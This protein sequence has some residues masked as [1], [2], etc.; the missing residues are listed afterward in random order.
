MARLSARLHLLGLIAAAVVPVWLFAAYLLAQ[1]AFTERARFESAAL[2]VARQ[3]SLVVEGEL[4]NLVTVLEGLSKSAA[5]AGGDL[6]TLHGEAVRLVQGTDRIILLRDLNGR[7]FVNT[8]LPYGTELPPA[9]PLSATEVA[10]LK[11]SQPVVSDVYASPVSNEYRIAVALPVRGPHGESWLLAITVP[12]AHIRDVMMPAVPVGW[13]LGV[14]DRN[15]NYVARSQLHEK[16]TGKPGL[17]EYLE[18]VVGRAGTFTSRNFQGMTLLAGYYR[19]EFSDWFYTANVPLSAVQAP[20]WRSLGAIGAIALVAMLVSGALAYVVGKGIARAAGDLAIRA[21]ALGHA[22][23]VAAMSTTVSEFAA[24]ADALAAAERA[25]AERASELETVLETAPAAVWFTYDP[26]A[27]QVIRN[28]FAAELMGLPTDIRKSFGAPDLVIDT[29]AL[30]DGHAVSREDRPLSRAMRGEQT[31]NEEFAYILPSGVER[32]LLSS[33]R[34]IR[35]AA[36]KIIG[37]VQISLDI[38]E[39]KRGEEQ[40]KLLVNE[41][42]HRVKN[43]LAVVQAIASQTLRNATSLPEAGRSL[44]SRLGSLAKAHD[45]LT[46][47]NWSGA[48]LQDLI[49]TSLAPHAGLDRFQLSGDSVWLPPNL[50][51]SLALAIHELTTN[52]IKYGALSTGGGTVS[53][54]WTVSKQAEQRRL[55]I[56]WREQGGPPVAPAERKGFGTRMLER[57]LD[58]ESGGSVTTTFEPTGVVCVFGVN[59]GAPGEITR[60][61]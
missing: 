13:T 48:N 12:T 16:M 22:R 24:I 47:E 37:A 29:I 21:D 36:D 44:A 10:K 33:A 51:L 34:P 39:R 2:Q 26:Q 18:K 28:R 61:P 1:Y 54:S 23:P 41:L 45:I 8:E 49:T 59:L 46:Q 38:S 55:R 52:A 17:P 6:N 25:L 15:G 32:T 20:L 27:R 4:T 60:V 7:Q 58:P 56:E 5:L 30:K 53:I 35:N 43:T 11:A 50:A 9:V 14:G 57:L 19:S 40:R 3:V 31:D 42:N